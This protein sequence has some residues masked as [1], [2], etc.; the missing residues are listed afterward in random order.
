MKVCGIF[1][2][3]MPLSDRKNILLYIWHNNY[4]VIGAAQRS[5]ISL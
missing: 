3:D 5:A 2:K 1:W 4:R